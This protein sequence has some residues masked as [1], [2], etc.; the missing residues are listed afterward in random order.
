MTLTTELKTEYR[1]SYTVLKLRVL[2][3]E[4]Q[5]ES[6]VK[7]FQCNSFYKVINRNAVHYYVL[8]LPQSDL[9]AKH[10][11]KHNVCKNK[12]INSF[13]TTELKTE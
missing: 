13:L 7:G 2:L 8:I 9:T 4:T 11:K 6:V 12:T 1:R 10:A 5:C 3:C